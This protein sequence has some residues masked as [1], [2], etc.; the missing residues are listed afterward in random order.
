MC[1]EVEND[2]RNMR[3]RERWE[4]RLIERFVCHLVEYSGME[5]K[6]GDAKPVHVVF[7]LSG[8]RNPVFLLSRKQNPHLTLASTSASSFQDLGSKVI[9][10]SKSPQTS[11]CESSSKGNESIVRLVLTQ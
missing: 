11:G 6:R 5:N 1:E 3:R 9:G 4:N 7:S 2:E 8:K 10:S